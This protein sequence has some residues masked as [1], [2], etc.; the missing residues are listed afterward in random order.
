MQ[1]M[2]EQ[3]EDYQ[4]MRSSSMNGNEKVIAGKHTFVGE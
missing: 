2:N 4:N 1:K 3:Q